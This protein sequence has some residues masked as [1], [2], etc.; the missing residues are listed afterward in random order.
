MAGKGLPGSLQTVASSLFTLSRSIAFRTSRNMSGHRI[1]T[2]TIILWA[3]I[4]FDF[5]TALHYNSGIPNNL[6]RLRFWPRRLLGPSLSAAHWDRSPQYGYYIMD[7]EIPA[8]QRMLGLSEAQLL[9]RVSSREIGDLASRSGSHGMPGE[10]VS[11][12]IATALNML[13]MSIAS[14]NGVE[15]QTMSQYLPRLRAEAL[16]ELGENL[17]NWSFDGT[18]KQE[19]DFNSMLYGSSDAI[20]P[21]IARLLACDMMGTTRQLRFYSQNEVECLSP[22]EYEQ[23]SHDRLPRFTI[24][25]HDMARRVRAA[26]VGTL[27]T[28]K[29][30]SFV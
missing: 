26:C 16:L 4:S 12:S 10:P 6:A 21:T 27:F 14:S 15:W 19:L 24:D 3:L 5:F 30:K 7:I 29:A 11:V 25:A 20:R 18:S 17:S 22:R 9:C 28:A 1:P 2:L 13:V 8:R 23:R